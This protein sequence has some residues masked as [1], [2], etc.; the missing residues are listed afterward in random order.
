MSPDTLEV[1]SHRFPHDRSFEEQWKYWKFTAA[2]MWGGISP[3]LP[4]IPRKSSL[5]SSLAGIGALACIPQSPQVQEMPTPTILIVTATPTETPPTPVTT[6]EPTATPRPKVPTATPELPRFLRET[7]I[8]GVYTGE[9]MTEPG[10]GG[11]GVVGEILF[12]RLPDNRVL[13]SFARF[14]KCPDGG[15]IT[16]VFLIRPNLIRGAGFQYDSPQ[17]GLVALLQS[18]EH[19]GGE[20]KIKDVDRRGTVCEGNPK[21]IIRAPLFRERGKEVVLNMLAAMLRKADQRMTLE[22]VT[23][24]VERLYGGPLLDEP[25][26]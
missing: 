6:L 18:L 21:L 8:Y 26:K 12:S 9:I 10:S 24:I 7:P 19:I 14:K 25:A 23:G 3:W 13:S 5:V 4:R 2:M 15:A 22:S 16:P 11:E 1:R 17:A 20:L